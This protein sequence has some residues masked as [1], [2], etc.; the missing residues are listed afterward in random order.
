MLPWLFVVEAIFLL[1]M[2]FCGFTLWLK[3]YTPAQTTQRNSTQWV[4]WPI[5][6]PRTTGTS[7]CQARQE[8]SHVHKSYAVVTLTLHFDF[9]FVQSLKKINLERWMHQHVARQLKRQFNVSI[10]SFFLS[11]F[12]FQFRS[13]E[14]LFRNGNKIAEKR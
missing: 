6:Q 12:F 10:A 7:R 2:F 5:D 8:F 13:F 11:V 14:W 9:S 4:R 3:I 1:P